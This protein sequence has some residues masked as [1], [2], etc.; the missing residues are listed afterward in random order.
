M[1]SPKRRG[2]LSEMEAM[3][4]LMRAGYTVLTAPYTDCARYDCVVDDAGRFLR[5]QIKTGALSPDG[6]VIRFATAS[7]NWHRRTTAPYTGQVELFAVFCPGNGRTY[8]VPVDAVGRKVAT[9]RLTPPRNGQAAG[10]RMAADYE[11]DGGAA[12][13]GAWDAGGPGGVLP[14]APHTARDTSTIAARA[15]ASSGTPRVSTTRT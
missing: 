4:A 15:A 12:I 5:V 14:T 3:L 9:L 2:E 1:R 11:L 13:G 8:L 7:N 10:L 6:S